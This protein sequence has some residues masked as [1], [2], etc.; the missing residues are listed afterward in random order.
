MEEMSD[1]RN[2]RNLSY[3]NSGG[4]K[5]I[6][7]GRKWKKNLI[8]E[9][10]ETWLTLIRAGKSLHLQLMDVSSMFEPEFAE[11]VIFCQ[12]RSC[13]QKENTLDGNFLPFSL[14]RRWQDQRA[15]LMSKAQLV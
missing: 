2:K 15:V 8:L 12:F 3:L 5:I 13:F 6:G 14:F 10:R 4:H 7:N 11:G 9:T 1:F